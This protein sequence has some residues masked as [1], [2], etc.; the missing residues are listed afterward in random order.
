MVVCLHQFYDKQYKSP[1]QSKIMDSILFF[2]SELIFP[3]YDIQCPVQSILDM[4]VSAYN[5]CKQFG[6]R[7]D[8]AQEIPFFYDGIFRSFSGDCLFLISDGFELFL[9]LPVFKPF[10]IACYEIFSYNCFRRRFFGFFQ[11]LSV[12]CHDL[13]QKSFIGKIF[14]HFMIC[15]FLVFL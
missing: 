2:G 8:T 11:I 3:E 1:D 6:S 4:P 15:G 10:D 13:L 7:L 14:F 12:C 9:F 5:D